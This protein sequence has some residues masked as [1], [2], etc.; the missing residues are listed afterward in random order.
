MPPP[1]LERW[2]FSPPLRSPIL[3]ADQRPAQTPE[4]PQGGAD[5]SPAS[6]LPERA[7]DPD[8]RVAPLRGAGVQIDGRQ[9]ARVL[10]AITLVTLAVLVVVFAIIGSDKNHQ[11]DQ[12]HDQGVAVQVTVT[13]CQGLLGGSGSNGAGYT[14]RGTYAL[15]G[16]R[17]NELLPGTALHAPGATIRAVAVPG[18]PALVSPVSIVDSEHTSASVYVLPGILLV[19]LAA[20]LVL[21]ALRRRHRPQVGGV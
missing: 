18:D 20:I 4:D 6:P 17:Y 15:Q 5:P 19:V 9:A 8:E 1:S 2:E 12:L 3:P 11:I 10:V 14:C 16:H 21:L 7:L 13:S